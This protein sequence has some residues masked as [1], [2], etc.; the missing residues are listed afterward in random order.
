MDLYRSSAIL[1]D[2][3]E[4]EVDVELFFMLLFPRGESDLG[5]DPETGEG[6]EDAGGLGGAQSSAVCR[7][8]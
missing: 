4:R 7:G 6:V 5:G 8:P 2:G 3:E 1:L